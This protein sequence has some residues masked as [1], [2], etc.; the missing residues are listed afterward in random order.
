MITS[1][2]ALFVGHPL[3]ATLWFCLFC[4]CGSETGR[5]DRN[6]LHEN[7][8]GPLLFSPPA[9]SGHGPWISRIGSN[10]ELLRRTSKSSGDWLDPLVKKDVCLSRNH[11]WLARCGDRGIVEQIPLATWLFTHFAIPRQLGLKIYRCWKLNNLG[12]INFSEIHC[13]KNC[14]K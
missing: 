10:W 8:W 2:F 3:F 1:D 9:G 4:L 13:H 6:C 14:H 5:L 12:R 7:P 11:I